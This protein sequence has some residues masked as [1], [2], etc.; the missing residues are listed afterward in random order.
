M[1]LLKYT[2]KLL[3]DKDIKKVVLLFLIWKIGLSVTTLLSI[4]LLPLRS[5]DFLGGGIE[6]YQ[7]APWFY[8]WA[9]FDGEH[10]L[11]IA[12]IG[13]RGLEQ[14]FFPV[15]PILM[16]L[17]AN[18]FGHT[19]ENLITMGLIISNLSFLLALILLWKLVVVDYSKK[20]AYL[21]IISL[22]LFPA[23]FYFGSLYNESPFLLMT[24][25]SFYLFRRKQ[26]F[27]ASLT[28]VL[29]SGTRVFGMFLTPSFLIEAWQ[30]KISFLNF[31]W[32][33]MIPV[34]LL[35]YMYYQLITV[36][37]P[38]A[39][40]NL[41]KIVGPQHESGITFLPQIYFRYIKMLLTTSFS[42]PIYQTIVLEFF[43]GILFFIL[44]LYGLFRKMRYSYVFYAL[45]GFLLPTIQGSF[46]S[47]PR[48][49]IVFFPG[50][51]ALAMLLN[52]MKPSVRVM[53]LIF[54]A[55]WLVLETA[56]FIR[57]YWVA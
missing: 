56:L 12:S 54:F 36:G 22:L 18:P 28:G 2:K 27:L 34:G 50:F 9:N 47:V 35:G 43:V 37:D 44:P 8:G 41:Q 38:I 49:V 20:I 14:A 48:Y 6:K 30:N 1:K 55:I 46:S 16:N 31:F 21:T 52:N 10:Y 7:A 23:S 53:I 11:S 3:Q 29:S 5:N 17:L 33:L 13:Y 32:I 51:I 40:Y 57:G 25:T 42:N 19:I 39:F 26:W 15:Y 45:I 24:V 4:K